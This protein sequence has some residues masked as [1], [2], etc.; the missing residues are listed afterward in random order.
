MRKKLF[1][2]RARLWALVH[3]LK[4]YLIIIHDI[5]TEKYKHCSNHIFN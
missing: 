4:I 3:I 1:N 5:D 2:I